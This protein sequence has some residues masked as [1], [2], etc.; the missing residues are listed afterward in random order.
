MRIFLTTIFT[1]ETGKGSQ[2]L[3]QLLA[4]LFPNVSD[5]PIRLQGK[6]L[7][8]IFESPGEIIQSIKKFY[9]N[10]TLRQVYRIIG[11]VIHWKSVLAFEKFV[12]ICG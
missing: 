5:A 10:E 3:P 11:C 12:L 7:N 1:P 9:V 4:A 2:S 8:H 6:A